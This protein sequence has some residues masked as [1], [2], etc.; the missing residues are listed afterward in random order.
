MERNFYALFCQVVQIDGTVR[1]DLIALGSEIIIGN[2]GRIEGSI[3]AA[4]PTVQI[5][6]YVGGSIRSV[7]NE[8][9][10]TKSATLTGQTSDISAFAL[11][12]KSDTTLP[13]DVWLVGR[14]V[15]FNSAIR[16]EKYTYL[17][18]P[19]L[20]QTLSKRLADWLWAT[21]QGWF[22][23]VT[24]GL[25]ATLNLHQTLNRITDIIRRRPIAT[26]RR[27][28]GL[29]IKG[30]LGAILLTFVLI[31]WSGLLVIASLG[32]FVVVLGISVAG[33]LI[34][35]LGIAV[36]LFGVVSPVIVALAISKGY[37]RSLNN[38]PK[39]QAEFIGLM[40]GALIV[41]A[42]SN[43]PLIGII[44]VQIFGAVGIGALWQS[45]RD[46]QKEA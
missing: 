2:N 13:G 4:S 11:I 22:G 42:L 45:W 14:D 31:G 16:G 40:V 35:L 30:G 37:Q 27:G 41:A 46:N 7:S 29:F 10:I 15:R 8:L 17:L 1:G 18:P 23:L 38:V 28:E 32:G 33:I 5:N 12:F 9:L 26:L 39:G 34:G 3:L 21:A 19:L 44:F 6:G 43:L 20:P 36:L 25:I 24:L